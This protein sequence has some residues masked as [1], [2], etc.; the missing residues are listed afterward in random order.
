MIGIVS[1]VIL[2]LVSR[3]LAAMLSRARVDKPVSTTAP[4]GVEQMDNRRSGPPW[5]AWLLLLLAPLLLILWWL[6]RR[7]GEGEPAAGQRADDAVRT[8]GATRLH[9]VDLGV[10]AGESE[11]PRAGGFAG[12]SEL[13]AEETGMAAPDD[14]TLIEGVGPK[15]SSILQDAGITTFAQLA[16]YTPQH[17]QT[18]LRAAGHRLADPT[19]WPEQARLLAAGDQAGFQALTSRLKGGRYTD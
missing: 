12:D 10:G 5:W 16:E 1:M 19:S 6:R 11:R 17:I 4:L 15:L 14:L 2:R 8:L 7:S 3:S 18:I 13:H 9:G